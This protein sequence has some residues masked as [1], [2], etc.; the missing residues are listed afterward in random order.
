MQTEPTNKITIEQKDY[1]LR[2]KNP[3][4]QTRI[5]QT[6]ELQKSVADG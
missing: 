2:K 3:F 6:G 4:H 1:R 5:F